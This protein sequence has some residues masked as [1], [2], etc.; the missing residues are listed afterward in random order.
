M[1]LKV[2]H[3]FLQ[4]VFTHDVSILRKLYLKDLIRFKQLIIN[5]GY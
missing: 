3:Y 2:K 5:G 1:T 4:Y